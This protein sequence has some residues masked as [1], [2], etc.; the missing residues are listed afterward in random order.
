MKNRK[1]KNKEMMEK[2]AQT[3]RE[4]FKIF[5]LIN[6]LGRDR[7]IGNRRRRRRRIE[8]KNEDGEKA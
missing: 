8:K 5:F 6:V 4:T 1:K 3:G 2:K 7:R